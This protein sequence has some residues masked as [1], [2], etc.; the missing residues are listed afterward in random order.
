MKQNLK[1]LKDLS[2]LKLHLNYKKSGAIEL[3]TISETT[4]KKIKGYSFSPRDDK[5]QLFKALFL[6]LGFNVENICHKEFDLFDYKLDEANQFL[7]NNNINYFVNYLTEVNR[8]I[9]FIE[10][11]KIK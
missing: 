7:K 1:H 2:T 10:L 6:T 9:S 4:I 8:N 5:G 11:I 3:K